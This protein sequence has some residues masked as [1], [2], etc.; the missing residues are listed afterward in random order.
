MNI[1]GW[2][3]TMDKAVL[4]EILR[5]GLEKVIEA[6]AA[7]AG[8]HTVTDDEI[9]YGLS[10]TGTVHPDEILANRNL[11]AGQVLVLSKPLGMGAF[12]TALKKQGAVD[13]ATY[14]AGCASMATLNNFACEIG[15]AHG[16]RAATDIT[17]FE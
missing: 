11:K 10:V 6:G 13:D 16:V 5:G 9:K 17:G 15:K 1:V 14:E 7:Q 4:T 8:G 3:K 2:P 12:S